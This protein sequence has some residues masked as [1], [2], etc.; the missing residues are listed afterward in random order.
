[1]S[2]SGAVNKLLAMGFPEPD[3][4]EA[5]AKVGNSVEAAV[6]LLAAPKALP[7][8]SPSHVSPAASSATPSTFPSAS[9]LA[10][11]AP[12]VSCGPDVADTPK[13]VRTVRS[14]ALQQQAHQ[15]QSQRSVALSG[16]VRPEAQ[17]LDAGL[18]LDAGVE[19]L[20]TSLPVPCFKRIG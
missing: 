14:T 7:S 16:Q 19:F 9:P 4:L 8:S 11:E 2:Q 18:D 1:M 3:A 6:D 15:S 13:P 17:I 20:F 12:T 5:L 10:A